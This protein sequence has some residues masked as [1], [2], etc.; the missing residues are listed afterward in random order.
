MKIYD[1]LKSNLPNFTS[2][3]GYPILYTMRDGTCLCG[4][5]ATEVVSEGEEVEGW[6]NWEM[7]C[8]CDGCGRVIEAAYPEEDGDD[9]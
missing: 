2:I 5:C 7:E 3:G 8:V 1:E 6:P 9:T 4:D